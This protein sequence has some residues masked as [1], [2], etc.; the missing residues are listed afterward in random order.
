MYRAS[1]PTQIFFI[2]FL[3]VSCAKNSEGN[4]KKDKQHSPPINKSLK[5]AKS[6]DK[7]LIN[8]KIK[9]INIIKSPL[10][11]SSCPQITHKNI[12]SISKTVFGRTCIRKKFL[13]KGVVT[14]EASRFKNISFYHLHRTKSIYI[15]GKERF[16][17]AKKH[18]Y[19]RKKGKKW[20]KV[21]LRMGQRVSI[22]GKRDKAGFSS[23]DLRIIRSFYAFRVKKGKDE[24][25]FNRT[26]PHRFEDH[27]VLLKGL[28]EKPKTF[29]LKTVAKILFP[30]KQYKPLFIDIGPGIANVDLEELD[31]KGIPA[32]TSIE[33]AEDFPHIPIIVMDLPSQVSIFMG[34]KEGRTRSGK[35]FIVSPKKRALL[36]K[37]PNIHIMSGNGLLSLKTQYENLKT[38]PIKTRKRP[39]ISNTTSLIIRAVNSIDIYCMYHKKNGHFPSLRSTFLRIA[40]DFKKIPVMFLFNRIIIIKKANS[41]KW[42]II[43]TISKMGFDH[44]ERGL[45][46]RGEPPFRFF[47][48][49][50]FNL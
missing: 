42:R 21:Y 2:F 9:P 49:F 4:N 15:N 26:F 7:P 38:N 5:T 11:P 29:Q 6:N 24:N 1:Y 27:H 18:G 43:G 30:S 32:V 20:R 34:T 36:L 48:D 16:L 17:R 8:H 37:H 22:H 25:V 46:R 12:D 41:T 19:Y 47:T 44:N 10:T 3:I 33:M 39:P 31:G 40:K 13:D 35:K 45:Y 50:H 28:I 14:I 23:K